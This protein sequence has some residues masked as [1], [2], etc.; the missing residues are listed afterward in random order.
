VLEEGEKMDLSG[1]E[2]E[3]YV[4]YLKRFRSENE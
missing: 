1:L 3:I 2:D 4:V